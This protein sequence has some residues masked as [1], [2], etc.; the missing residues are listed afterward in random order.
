MGLNR[1]FGT[2]AIFGIS[3]LIYK[4][5]RKQQEKAKHFKIKK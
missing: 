4:Q 3:L 5:W 1:I 2:L